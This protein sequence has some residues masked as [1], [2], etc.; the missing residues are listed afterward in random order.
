[1]QTHQRNATATSKWEYRVST[2]KGGSDPFPVTKKS[3]SKN[4]MNAA[5]HIAIKASYETDEPKRM[6]SIV[7]LKFCLSSF[8]KE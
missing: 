2:G 1:M 6:K 8:I 7:P 3:I 4:N 5:V